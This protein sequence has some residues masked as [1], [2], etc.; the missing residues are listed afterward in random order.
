MNNAV[1]CVKPQ[2]ADGGRP[3]SNRFPEL[4]KREW[5]CH[6][7]VLLSLSGK[8]SA[9]RKLQEQPKHTP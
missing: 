8:L 9:I 6:N 4:T 1:G 3:W 7:E 5:S 2:Q